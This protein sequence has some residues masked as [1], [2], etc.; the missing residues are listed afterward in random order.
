VTRY[1]RAEVGGIGRLTGEHLHFEVCYKGIA[2]PPYNFVNRCRLAARQ[3][4]LG[5]VVMSYPTLFILAVEKIKHDFE[6]IKKH[7]R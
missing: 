3:Q 2:E 4:V 5:E 7:L 6:S 1:A